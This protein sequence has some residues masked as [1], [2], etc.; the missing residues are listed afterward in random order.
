MSDD[1]AALRKLRRVLEEVDDIEG[2]RN[3]CW[4]LSR[5]IVTTRKEEKR[6]WAII[7]AMQAQN[8]KDRA[9]NLLRNNQ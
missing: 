6:L 7:H 2:L 1:T 9:D 4:D 3:I 5:E 8:I